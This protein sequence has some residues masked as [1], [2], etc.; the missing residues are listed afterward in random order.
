MKS[1]VSITCQCGHHMTLVAS[2]TQD[3]EENQCPKCHTPF[4]FI[5]PLGNFVGIRIFNRAWAELEN[6]DF[7]LLIVLSAM[8]V[9]CELARLFIKW[10][11][12]DV[13]DK[14]MPTQADRDGWAEQWRKWTQ[15][16]VRLDKVSTL[17]TGEDFDSYLA[18]NPGLLKSVQATYPTFAVGASTKDSFIKDIFH[19][20]NKIVHQ[21]EIDF[22]QADAEM[23]FTLAAALFD[24]LKDMDGKRQEVL[25]AK[26]AAAKGH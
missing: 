18:H 5:Q 8:A 14:T 15:I 9:E 2:G 22:Q 10:N 11:E 23:C 26:H 13:M 12:I 1:T 20:R 21:G 4:W 19:K 16:G 24:I 6:K 17:L 25:A 3:P 7:T